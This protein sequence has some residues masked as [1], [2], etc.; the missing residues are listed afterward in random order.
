MYA[1]LVLLALQVP[2]ANEVSPV[3]HH[4]YGRALRQ[5]E[6][7]GKPMAVFIGWGGNGPGCLS[8]KGELS[9]EVCRLLAVSYVCL[10]IDAVEPAVRELVE[11]FEAAEAPTLVLSDA[12]RT[13]QAFRH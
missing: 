2:C 11:A 3:W 10:Y 1:C 8:E 12:S 13:Y 4:D 9:P 6:A 5:A 7:V